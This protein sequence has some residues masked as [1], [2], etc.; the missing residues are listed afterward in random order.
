MRMGEAKQVCFLPI[1][2]NLKSVS[3]NRFFFKGPQNKDHSPD[4]SGE[5]RRVFYTLALVVKNMPTNA[6]DLRDVS[7]MPGSG[8]SAGEGRG[9]PLQYSCLKDPMTEAPGGL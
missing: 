2:I 5:Y 9:N 7:S 4:G 8:I 3:W 6:G 1:E